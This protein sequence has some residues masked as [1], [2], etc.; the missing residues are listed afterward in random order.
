M[1]VQQ[2]TADNSQNKRHALKARLG[3]TRRQ[4]SGNKKKIKNGGIKQ[5]IKASHQNEFSQ[6]IKKMANNLGHKMGDNNP[7]PQTSGK[8]MKR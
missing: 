3:Q 1:L 4:F 7:P 6:L 8:I 2:V 5:K